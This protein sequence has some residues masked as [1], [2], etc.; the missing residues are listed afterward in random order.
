MYYHIQWTKYI[1]WIKKINRIKHINENTHNTL[2]EKPV[3]FGRGIIRKVSLETSIFLK[4]HRPTTIVSG[5]TQTGNLC[6][7][8][9][10]CFPL[11]HRQLVIG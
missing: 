3:L 10:G 11:L 9:P 8:R 5:R 6:I 7:I 2:R 4:D 1:I